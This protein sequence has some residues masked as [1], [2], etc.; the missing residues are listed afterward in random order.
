MQTKKVRS[1]GLVVGWREWV[2]LPDLGVDTIK[3]KVDTGARSSSLHVFDMKA[4][5]RGGKE[6][7]R[8]KVHPIQRTAKECIEAKAE[9]L[10][11]RQIRSSGGHE[12]RRPVIITPVRFLDQIWNIELTL[13]ARD[14]MGFRMLLG[15]EA[16]RNRFLVDPGRSFY[17]G[18]PARKKRGKRKQ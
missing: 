1:R 15:R 8:F 16:V 18:K 9:V 12:S 2:A 14:A 5:K 17:G 7:V 10:E 6:M 13:A 11:Y 4:F 3:A